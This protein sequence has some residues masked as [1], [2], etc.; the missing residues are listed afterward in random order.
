MKKY[1]EMLRQAQQGLRFWT[2]T[3]MREFVATTLRRMEARDMSRVQLAES[4]QVSPA[5]VSKV[6][7]GQANFTLESMVK[8]ARAVGGRLRVDIIDDSVVLTAERMPG[9]SA[10]HEFVV[11]S[12]RTMLVQHTEAIA[13]PVANSEPFRQVVGSVA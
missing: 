12:G 8:I 10:K 2:H 9:S 4:L 3:A 1:A 7:R 6:L 11:P 13:L 5:Y